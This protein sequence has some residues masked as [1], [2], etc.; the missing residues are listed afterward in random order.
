MKRMLLA[1]VLGLC[2]SISLGQTSATISAS[3]PLP[4]TVVGSAASA[5]DGSTSVGTTPITLFGGATPA[6]G[7]QIF[8]QSSGSVEFSDVGT[9]GG[10]GS[11]SMMLG[12]IAGGT[13]LYTT[14]D[15]YKPAGPVSIVAPSGTQYVAAR[16]W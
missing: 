12:P 3:T 15:G 6:H 14:P 1:A 13:L 8:L 2:A 7:F 11:S 16:M 10:L 4:V 9:A 5:V